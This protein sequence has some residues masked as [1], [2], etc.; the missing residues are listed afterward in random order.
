MLTTLGC[1]RRVNRKAKEGSR[2][3]DRDGQ[4]QHINRQ[5][6]AVQSNGHDTKKKELIGEYRNGGRDY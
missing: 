6:L 1:P 3:S 5:V 4:F 2:H